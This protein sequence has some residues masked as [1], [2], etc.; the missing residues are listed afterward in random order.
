M[1]GNS[2]ERNESLIMGNDCMKALQAL[3]YS[4]V[5]AIDVKDFSCL[6]SSIS[7][8]GPE[9]VF[10]AM[11]GGFG[12]NGALCGMLDCLNIPYTHSGQLATATQMDKIVAKT[13]VAENGV[14][15]KT[16]IVLI[17]HTEIIIC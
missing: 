8:F 4:N 12:E 16:Y 13:I 2:S 15:G 10:N 6:P 9:L 14:L 5:R 7:Q 3:G 1:G 17:I 11:Q